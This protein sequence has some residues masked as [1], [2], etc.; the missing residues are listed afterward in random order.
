LSQNVAGAGVAYSGTI[1]G[2]TTGSSVSATSSDSTAITVSGDGATATWSTAGSP[3]IDFTET[4]SGATNSP[5]SSVDS[6]FVVEPLLNVLGLTPTTIYKNV[7]YSGTI[8]N[9]T[10]G[11]TVGATSSDSTV[12]TVTGSGTTRTVTGTFAT[13]GSPTITL[14]ETKSGT[15]NSPKTTP[16]S[17]T[18]TTFTLGTLTLSPNSANVGVAYSGTISG[19]ATHGSSSFTATSSDGTVLTVIGTAVTG[20]FTSTGSPTITLTETNSSA[21]NSPHVTTDST[22]TVVAAF[23]GM[24]DSL[25]V[26]PVAA[27]SLR[28]LRSAYAGACIN[29]RR[30]SDNTTLDIGFVASG[31]NKVLDVASMQTFVGAGNGYIAKFYDQMGGGASADIVQT[32]S[33]Q[34]PLVCAS[35]VAVKAMQ[36][37]VP[38]FGYTSAWV[39]G[40]ASSVGPLPAS[41]SDFSFSMACEWHG[42]QNFIYQFSGSIDFYCPYTSGQFYWDSPGANRIGPTADAFTS[43]VGGTVTAVAASNAGTIY[44][45]GASFATGTTGTCVPTEYQWNG[46]VNGTY[47]TELIVFAGNHLTSG[48]VS[49]IHTSQS[50]YFG[51]P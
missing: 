46:A 19:G 29:V 10:A 26:A 35:G 5:H 6:T 38:C 47:N 31:A 16:I 22:F 49:A 2:K 44:F 3:T 37:S 1:T 27:Y 15:F 48:D 17:F 24:L 42:S 8:S 12:L 41:Y 33:S 36:N 30:D 11:S 20:T 9:C 25:S 51:T 32:G 40:I 21:S 4:L 14:T 39:L 43:G 18:V 34:Q 28:L 45:N 7:A 50:A 23:S 13:A